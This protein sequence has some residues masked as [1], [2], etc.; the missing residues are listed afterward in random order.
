MEKINI[1][2]AQNIELEETVASVGERILATLIDY[3]IF[4]PYIIMFSI[5]G[6]S[7]GMTSKVYWVVIF[8]PILFYDLICELSMNGQ[9][10]GK[11][12]MKIK[13]VKLDGS[14]PVA[15][16]YFIRW[17]FRLLDSVLVGGAIATLTIIING[18]GQRVGDIAAN[19]TVI[20]VK[21]SA[22]LKDTI[23]V[24]LPENYKPVFLEAINLSENDVYTINEVIGFCNSDR[25]S[26]VSSSMPIST[27][28]AITKKLSIITI[29]SPIEF[30]NTIMNDYNYL[31]K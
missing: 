2:T 14:F 30:L 20:R 21:K 8:L 3:L 16:D 13:V 5:L 25:F 29:L 10:I 26:A 12:I 19:T 11:R 24:E 22:N 9:N 4:T 15:R 7:T 1:H 27:K 28:D 17:V 23:L 6:I 31:N 18:R